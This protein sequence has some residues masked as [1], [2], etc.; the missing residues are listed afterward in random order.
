MKENFAI[1]N[2]FGD[3]FEATVVR[4]D[5]ADKKIGFVENLKFSDSNFIP[6]LKR[7]FSFVFYPRPYK[8]ILIFSPRDATGYH[9][10]VSLGRDDHKKKI[11]EEELGDLV[12]SA[13]WKFFDESR[14]KASKQLSLG[15]SEI[16]LS[17]VSVYDFKLDGRRVIDPLKESAGRVEISLSQTFVKREF[18]SNVLA[19]LPKRIK[20]V[21]ILE[22]GVS[23]SH[24]LRRA[25]KNDKFIFAKT[26]REKTNIFWAN[27]E[28]ICFFDYFDWGENSIYKGISDKLKIN[29]S[30]SKSIVEKFLNHQMSSYFAKNFKSMF[31]NEIITLIQGLKSGGDNISVGGRYFSRGKSSLIYL[32]FPFLKEFLKEGLKLK[33]ISTKMIVSVNS[34][35]I[36]ENFGFE[37]SGQPLKAENPDFLTVSALL[38]VYFLPIPSYPLSLINR[39]AKRRMRWL[40]PN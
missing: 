37:L 18:L 3:D 33:K 38:E 34:S 2:F 24:L 8:V 32:D 26:T 7:F 17:D 20:K 40:I 4:A 14:L 35:E 28:K 25:S 16:I 9:G 21:F 11:T 29:V 19:L 22:G 15:E 12:S 39:L 5:F 30:E 13:V 23:A 36:F 1:I 31:S 10:T 6:V 27:K